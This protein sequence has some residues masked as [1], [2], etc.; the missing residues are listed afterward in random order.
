MSDGLDGNPGVL[1][2]LHATARLFS[3]DVLAPSMC[4]HSAL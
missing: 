1:I 2:E 4:S 3:F